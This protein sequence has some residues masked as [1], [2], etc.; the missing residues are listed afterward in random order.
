ME[1]QVEEIKTPIRLEY[2]HTAGDATT[3][4]L[5]AIKE[6]R[7]LGQRCPKCRLVIVPARGACARC[8]VPTREEVEL[9][10]KGTVTTFCVVHLPI[11]GSEVKPPFVCATIQLDGADIGFFHLVSEIQP[12]QVRA[13]MRVQGV[14]KPREAWDYTL[15]NIRYF[16]PTGEPDVELEDTRSTAHA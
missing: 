3:R 1:K 6:G 5:R 7:I 2:R 8:G 4:F 9:P 10:D 15:E 13:G 11:P 16:K 12:D 14:W